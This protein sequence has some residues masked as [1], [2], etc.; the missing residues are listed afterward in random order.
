MNITKYINTKGKILINRELVKVDL[1]IAYVERYK[2]Q[3]LT[4]FRNGKI[5][6]IIPFI[7]IKK[8]LKN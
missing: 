3:E 2:E 1:Q 5:L 6:A 4:I 7:E 8:L